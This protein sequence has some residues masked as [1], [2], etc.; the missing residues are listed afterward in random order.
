MTHIETARVKEV[1]GF[2][3]AAVKEAAARLDVDGDLQ[4][5]E[6]GL[7]ALEQSVADLKESL[8]GLPYRHQPGS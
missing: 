7:A 8:A 5:L 2:K 3:I 6:A 1:M 4:E